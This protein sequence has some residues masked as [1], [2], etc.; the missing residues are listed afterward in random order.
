M[1][2][3]VKYMFIEQLIVIHLKI[4]FKIKAAKIRKRKKMQ[5]FFLFALLIWINVL[6]FEVP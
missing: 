6:K 4:F 2:M 5:F 3:C 1:K